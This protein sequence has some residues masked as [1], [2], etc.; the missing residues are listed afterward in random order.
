MDPIVISIVVIVLVLGV[1]YSLGVLGGG[2]DNTA[3]ETAVNVFRA[4]TGGGLYALRKM[5]RKQKK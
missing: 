1:G 5:R 3:T 4:T 2:N